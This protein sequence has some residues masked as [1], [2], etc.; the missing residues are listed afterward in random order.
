VLGGKV[1]VPTLS[2]N[3]SLTIPPG[4]QPGQK[5]RLSGRGM[6]ILKSANSFGDLYVQVNVEIPKK[7]TDNQRRLFEEMK[8][9]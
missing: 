4:T 5:F 6:P 7:L 9:L 2:G 1:T 3:V 8:K